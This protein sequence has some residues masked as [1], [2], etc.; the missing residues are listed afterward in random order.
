M[1]FLLPRELICSIIK[2]RVLVIISLTSLILVSA[3]LVSLGGQIRQIIDSSLI[4][5]HFLKQKVT[6]VVCTLFIFSLASFARA[7]STNRLANDIIYQ[8]RVNIYNNLLKLKISYHEENSPSKLQ[9]G[10]IEDVQSVAVIL[11]E[12]FSFFIRNVL[13]FVSSVIF[14]Y[15]Q[16]KILLCVTIGAMLLLSAPLIFF[17]K[18][19]KSLNNN[20]R[21]LLDAMAELV[22]KTFDS[23]KLVYSYNLEN[24][25]RQE[26]E[27]IGQKIKAASNASSMFRSFVF[28]L[29]IFCISI[30]ITVIIW[31]G[32]NQILANKMTSGSLVAFMIYALM[33]VSS[34]IAILNNITELQPNLIRLKQALTFLKLDDYED[35]SCRTQIQDFQFDIIFDNVNFSYNSRK[36]KLVL[37]NFSMHIEFG[38]LVLL[39]GISGAG[40]STILSLLLKFYEPDSGSIKINNLAISEISNYS[41]RQNF[42]L[43][44]QD[45]LIFPASILQNITLGRHYTQDELTRSIQ[46]CGLENILKTLPEGLQT[47]VG[48]KGFRLS[49]GQKQ[50]ICIARS[51]LLKPKVLML[52]EATNALDEESQDHILNNIRSSFGNQTVIFV[53]HKQKIAKIFDEIIHVDPVLNVT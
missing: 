31:I 13:I 33:S 10:I 47:F 16:N 46:I 7:T 6:E 44:N 29:Y 19:S 34:L 41:M 27:K 14:M 21:D 8:F 36:E 1:K 51:L 23:I 52:D 43:V 38:K 2:H 20:T 30:S 24:S 5:Q 17:I 28:A 11:Q 35:R 53:S 42:A 12:I 9:Q 40:K 26:F 49:G 15:L 45:P 50:R 32:S 48:Q 39:S 18:S 4:D 3:S 22:F 37:M 25:S